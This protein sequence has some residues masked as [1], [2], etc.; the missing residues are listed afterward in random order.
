MCR[1]RFSPKTGS[2]DMLVSDKGVA[3]GREG[4]TLV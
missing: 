4:G 2:G 3:A 1:S